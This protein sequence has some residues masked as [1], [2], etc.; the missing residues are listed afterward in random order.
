MQYKNFKSDGTF[1]FSSKEFWM[2]AHVMYYIR[3]LLAKLFNISE[4]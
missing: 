1:V 4:K 3:F 2:N